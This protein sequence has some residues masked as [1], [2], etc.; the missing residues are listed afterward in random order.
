MSLDKFVRSYPIEEVLA[1]IPDGEDHIGFALINGSQYQI[2][3]K[4]GHLVHQTGPLAKSCLK[5][6]PVIRTDV[7][8]IGNCYH[9]FL[10]ATDDTTILKAKDLLGGEI[11]ESKQLAVLVTA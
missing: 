10:L 9:S 7:Y 2:G 6:V 8:A 3:D 5:S 1:A 11:L 4:P